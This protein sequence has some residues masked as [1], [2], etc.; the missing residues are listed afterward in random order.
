MPLPENQPLTD[1]FTVASVL[2]PFGSSVLDVGCAYGEFARH[3]FSYGCSVTGIEKEPGWAAEADHWCTRT[4]VGDVELLDL[5]TELAGETFDVITCLDVLEHLKDPAA[6]LVRLSRLLRPGGRL[7]FSIPNVSHAALRLLLLGGSFKRTD[8]GLLD[9]THLQFFDRLGLEKMLADVDMVVTDRL[10]VRRGV[11]Q[12]EIDLD[13]AMFPEAALS[14]AL[15][16][17]DADV[18]QFVWSV[19]PVGTQVA[20][21]GAEDLWF[22]L[23]LARAEIS[24]LRRALAEGRQVSGP[25]PRSLEDLR[26]QLDHT[27]RALAHRDEVATASKVALASC[28]RKLAAVE[29]TLRLER[30]R[31]SYRATQRAIRA[32]RSVSPIRWMLRR[33]RPGLW[34]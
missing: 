18:Y 15:A 14:T 30:G 6:A 11:D 8:Q 5:E 34:R 2:I 33:L 27:R 24:Q 9:R 28:N 13:L 4:I 1:T 23:E 19:A 26:W 31:I 17:A 22:E 12:T 20:T 32:L 29:K 7:V 25:V 21:L 16:G 10:Y 3:L